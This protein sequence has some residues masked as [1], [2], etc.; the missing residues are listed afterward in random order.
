[1]SADV[2][3][4]FDV[5]ELV[6]LFGEPLEWSNP[7]LLD[8]WFRYERG[9]GASLTLSLSGYERS[10]SVIVRGVGGAGATSVRI[11]RCDRVQ[12]LEPEL[13]TLEVVGASPP[14]RC[15]LALEADSLLEVHVSGP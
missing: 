11:D 12:V 3:L 8:Y 4:V 13:G 7:E 2:N 9:D 1:M 5:D 10:V 15:F 14:I 6:A